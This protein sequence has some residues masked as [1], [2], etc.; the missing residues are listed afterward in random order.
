MVTLNTGCCAE[1][2]IFGT[3]PWQ[4]FLGS[5][6]TLRT[7]GGGFA[8]PNDG[9]IV[10]VSAEWSSIIASDDDDIDQ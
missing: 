9:H 1:L 3:T 2:A 10:A 8:A 7:K 6:G 5:P 4:Q